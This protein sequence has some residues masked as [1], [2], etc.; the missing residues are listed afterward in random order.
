L[1]DTQKLWFLLLKYWLQS[2]ADTLLLWW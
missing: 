1:P 2:K